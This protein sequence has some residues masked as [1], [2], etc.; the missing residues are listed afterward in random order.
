MFER[1]F[2]PPYGPIAF[3]MQAFHL[4]SLPTVYL[5]SARPEPDGLSWPSYQIMLSGHSLDRPE[6]LTMDFSPLIEH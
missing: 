4:T 2:R 3:E 5:K 1:L 6:R